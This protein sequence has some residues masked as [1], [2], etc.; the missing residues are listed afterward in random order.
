MAGDDWWTDYSVKANVVYYGNNPFGII[1][2]AKDF[3]GYGMMISPMISGE[4]VVGAAISINRIDFDGM[5]WTAWDY[6][7]VWPSDTGEANVFTTDNLPAQWLVQV[8][9]QDKKAWVNVESIVN[10]NKIDWKSKEFDLTDPNAGTLIKNGYMG[11]WA[12]RNGTGIG[13]TNVEVDKLGTAMI[14]VPAQW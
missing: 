2:R 13:V 4:K 8:S 1:F 10:N 6:Q 14:S 9:V 3:D 5:S 7:Y 11:I 12:E